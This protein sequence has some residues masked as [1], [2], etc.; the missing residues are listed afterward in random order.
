[1]VTITH[2]KSKNTGGEQRKST[3]NSKNIRNQTILLQ[4]RTSTFNH[5]IIKNREN[6][7]MV[8]HY[9]QHRNWSRLLRG[10]RVL[11]LRFLLSVHFS[12]GFNDLLVFRGPPLGATFSHL[13][14]SGIYHLSSGWVHRMPKSSS[15][16]MKWSKPPPQKPLTPQR[17]PSSKGYAL[18]CESISG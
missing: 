5:K 15:W 8:C 14:Q 17:I 13:V 4:Q 3:F 10:T 6:R 9:H 12:F 1:M 2:S 7:Q 18:V 11:L 16:K